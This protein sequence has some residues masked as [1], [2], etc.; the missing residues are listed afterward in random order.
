MPDVQ[1]ALANDEGPSAEV[2]SF[3]FKEFTAKGDNLACVVASVDVSYTKDSHQLQKSYVVKVNPLRSALGMENVSRMLFEK[4]IGFYTVLAPLLNEELKKLSLD[5]LK[6]PKCFH[7][8]SE[9]K[10]EVIFLEDLRKQGYK[11]LDRKLGMDR[12]HTLLVLKELAILH[13]I[14]VVFTTNEN[15]KVEDIEKKFPFL[16]EPYVRMRKLS[17]STEIDKL[18]ASMMTASAEVAD[19]NKGYEY[20][21]DFL[22]KLIPKA[23][24]TM[25]DFLKPKEPFVAI[26]HGDCWNNNFLFR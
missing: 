22:R 8:V 24:S 15:L 11:M 10:E 20:A 5:A 1:K 9:D 17:A 2:K 19:R 21:G 7:S 6:I 14:S 12:K 26:C 25:I 13:A 16:E 4:E 23:N 3:Q 18:Y